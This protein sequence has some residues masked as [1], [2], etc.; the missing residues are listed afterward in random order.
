MKSIKK[1]MTPGGHW[2]AVTGHVVSEQKLDMAAASELFAVTAVAISDAFVVCW[3]AKYYFQ[4][5]RP[6]SYIHKNITTD[7]LPLLQTPPF[8]EQ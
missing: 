1:K 8:P 7:W 4:S 3:D 5:I 2:M 6:I